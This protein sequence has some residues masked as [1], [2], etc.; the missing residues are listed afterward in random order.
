VNFFSARRVCP[1]WHIGM[2]ALPFWRGPHGAVLH[3]YLVW[4]CVPQD[5]V[6]QY[7]T[8]W[9]KMRA[10]CSFSGRAA[11]RIKKKRWKIRGRNLRPPP[12]FSFSREP[13]IAH[14]CDFA[15]ARKMFRHDGFVA[16][17]TCWQEKWHR[18]R[19]QNLFAAGFMV[20]WR[21]CCW[22]AAGPGAVAD[23]FALHSAFLAN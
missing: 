9:L 23:I 11:R 14:I 6:N 17:W 5:A 4:C 7:I 1:P 10:G 15:N 12:L 22:N 19:R 16:V 21:F 3:F 18:V 13:L 20:F 8:A 2:V